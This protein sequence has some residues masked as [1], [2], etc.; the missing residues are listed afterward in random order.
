MHEPAAVQRNL[1]LAMTRATQPSVVHQGAMLLPGRPVES[2]S[3]T[4]NSRKT[5]EAEEQEAGV[6]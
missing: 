3:M 2:R 4:E 6:F 1:S 5:D